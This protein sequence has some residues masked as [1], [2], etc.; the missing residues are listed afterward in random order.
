M[1]QSQTPTQHETCREAVNLPKQSP[2]RFVA[3]IF[4]AIG[5]TLVGTIYIFS[6]RLVGKTYT[7]EVKTTRRLQQQTYGRLHERNT[8]IRLAIFSATA[9]D[10]DHSDAVGRKQKHDLELAAVSSDSMLI[11]VESINYIQ[12]QNEQGSFVS[13][14]CGREAF[15]R[16]ESLRST[17]AHLAIALFQWCAMYSSTSESS[18]VHA[19]LF[20]DSSSPIVLRGQYSTLISYLS[21]YVLLRSKTSMLPNVAVLGLDALPETIHGSFLLL[22]NSMTSHEM[23]EEMLRLLLNSGTISDV[24]E[25]NTML[26]SKAL[27][28]LISKQEEDEW[29]FLNQHCRMQPPRRPRNDETKPLEAHQSHLVCP[30]STG[31]CCKI[32]DKHKSAFTVMMTRHLMIPYQMLDITKISSPFNYKRKQSQLSVMGDDELPYISTISETNI[33]KPTSYGKTPTFYEI[34]SAKRCLPQDDTCSRCLREKKGANCSTCKSVCH[35]FCKALCSLDDRPRQRH[36]SKTVTVTPPAYRR[37]PTRLIPR[38]VHQTWFEALT[39]TKYPNMSRMVQ[40]FIRSGWEYKFYTDAEAGAFLST[41]FPKEIREAY[42]AIRP[43][44]FKADLFRYCVL[45]IHGGVYADV[46]KLKLSISW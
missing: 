41:H 42:D 21:D 14:N 40:S 31:Y 4:V 35:C 1:Q 29:Y 39:S 11:N 17:N 8:P 10:D 26:L 22:R 43:G 16:F 12:N 5:V 44:A 30:M 27:H 3:I 9:F 36:V 6:E 19:V 46:G 34:L 28:T 7:Q 24:I 25:A 23:A 20:L 15:L 18:T 33:P 13:E 38:I 2:S 45:L 37:D 32:Q